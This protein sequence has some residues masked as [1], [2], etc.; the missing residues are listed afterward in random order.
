M[1]S[2]DYRSGFLTCP[3][4]IGLSQFFVDKTGFSGLGRAQADCKDF[5]SHSSFFSLIKFITTP[6]FL[7]ND[8]L[9]F[10]CT[11]V[12]VCTLGAQIPQEQSDLLK[13]Y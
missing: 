6:P 2:L 4:S 9:L 1:T 8:L 11:S 13:L 10:L 5:K 12:F 3:L 7:K